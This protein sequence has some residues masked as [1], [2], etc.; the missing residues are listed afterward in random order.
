MQT[1]IDLGLPPKRPE[2]FYEDR[3]SSRSSMRSSNMQDGYNE[4]LNSYRRSPPRV[5]RPPSP[6]PQQQDTE[7]SAEALKQ[8]MKAVNL[9]EEKDQKEV[10]K[11]M[12]D[13]NQREE[14]MRQLREERRFGGKSVP[15]RPESPPQVV[16]THLTNSEILR[17]IEKEW[18]IESKICG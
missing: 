18:Q 16:T 15:D 14:R 6:P 1:R 17:V 4:T 8:I 7:F 12:D 13:R 5:R 11:K 2:D 3:T 9:S 10:M